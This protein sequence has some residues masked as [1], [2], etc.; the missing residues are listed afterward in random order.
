[1]RRWKPVKV[2]KATTLAA[3]A[4]ANGMTSTQLRWYNP[5]LKGTKIAA[6][7]TINVPSKLAIERR[8]PGR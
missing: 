6:G 1:M 5:K 2:K 4:K 8:L 3:L 7:A